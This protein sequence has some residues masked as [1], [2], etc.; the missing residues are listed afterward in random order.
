MQ[1]IQHSQSTS[2]NTNAQ[3]PYS[4]NPPIN[5]QANI[6]IAV[7]QSNR[8]KKNK[9]IQNS[10]NIKRRTDSHSFS[11]NSSVS[12]G[13]PSVLTRRWKVETAVLIWKTPDA[14]AC[15]ASCF[16]LMRSRL[17]GIGRPCSRSWK[18]ILL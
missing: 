6:H 10:N 13:V 2:N 17:S 16:P 8:P 7:N 1:P 5:F 4:P 9:K 15:V 12:L 11:L 3:N 18:L 14:T